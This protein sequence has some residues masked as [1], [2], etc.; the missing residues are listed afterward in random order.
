MTGR[1]RDLEIP[2]LMIFD[3]DEAPLFCRKRRRAC[4]RLET[5]IRSQQEHETWLDVTRQRDRR[6]AR[7]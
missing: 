4:S 1:E 2:A 7:T 3:H 6:I 5:R